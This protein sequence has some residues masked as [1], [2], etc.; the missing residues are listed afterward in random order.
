ME[1]QI[2]SIFNKECGKSVL[3]QAD[4]SD[5]EKINILVSPQTVSQIKINC[6]RLPK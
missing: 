6:L 5:R 3:N 1:S 2:P 4:D